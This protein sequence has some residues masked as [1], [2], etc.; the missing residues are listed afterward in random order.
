VVG[1][2][3][4]VALS[5]A[6]VALEAGDLTGAVAAVDT[7]KGAPAGAMARWVADAKALLGARSALADMA[8]HA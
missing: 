8:D 5:R 2:P 1:N 6:Q 7:L 4:A 3:S